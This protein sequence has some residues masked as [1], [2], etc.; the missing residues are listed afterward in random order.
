[1]ALSK[2][3]GTNFIAPTLPVASGGTGLT[4]G[5]VNGGVN[6]PAVSAYSNANQTVSDNTSTKVAFNAEL[7]DTDSAFDT[8]TYRFTVPSGKAGK[9][10]I[11]TSVYEYGNNNDERLKAIDIQLNGAVVRR[12]E[13]FGD[14]G[15]G[16]SNGGNVNLSAVL[17]L[18]AADYIE[19]FGKLDVNSGTPAFYGAASA[20]SRYTVLE[21][22]RL[23]E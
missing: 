21:I 4:S 1:M 16:F 7:Y 9:Y 6:T 13:I 19:I 22:F 2:I 8:S 10:Y 18:S 15:T 23:L 3:D 17:D 12:Y 11:F 14:S 20:A 5:F